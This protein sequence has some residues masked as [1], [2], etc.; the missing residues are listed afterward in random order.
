LSPHNVQALM[1]R[2]EIAEAR[3][4]LQAALHHFTRALDV[5]ATHP[6]PWARRAQVRLR[7]GDREGARADA[8]RAL[9]LNEAGLYDGSEEAREVLAQLD[10]ERRSDAAPAGD[11]ERRSDAAPPGSEAELLR[12][13]APAGDAQQLEERYRR[14]R[15]RGALPE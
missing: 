3:G 12:D 2:G 10:A 15:A 13:A 7:L 8:E 1:L 5:V 11:A 9:K 4:D 6:H 14:L